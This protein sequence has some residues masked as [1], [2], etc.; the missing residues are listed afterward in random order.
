MCADEEEEGTMTEAERWL[1]EINSPDEEVRLRAVRDLA[2][3]R[4]EE[5]LGR[6]AEAMGDKSWRIRKEAAEAVTRFDYPK[7]IPHLLPGLRDESNAG[8]RNS[9]VEVLIRFGA[10]VVPEVAGLLN[11]DDPDIRKFT[12][13]I[14]GGIDS[15]E[16]VPLLIRALEDESENVV[17]AAAEYLGLKH[18]H[19]AVS[20][21]LTLLEKESFWLRFCALRALGQLAS[22]GQE[23]EVLPFLEDPSLRMETI[24][25]LARIGGERAFARMLELHGVSSRRERSRILGALASILSRATPGEGKGIGELAGMIPGAGLGEEF[26]MYLCEVV[27][28]EDGEE[29]RVAIRVSSLFPSEKVMAALVRNMQEAR[30]EDQEEICRAMAEFPDEYM[31]SLFPYLGT[32]STLVRRQLVSVFG[33]RRYQPALSRLLPLIKDEDGHVRASVATALGHIGDKSAIMPLFDLLDDP[34]PDVRSA[35]VQALTEMASGNGETGEMI[36]RFISSAIDTSEER[37]TENFLLVLGS[38]ADEALIPLFARF[39]KDPRS[40]IRRAA[41]SGLGSLDTESGLEMILKALT[42]EDP[43]I[44]FEAVRHLGRSGNE[45]YLKPILAMVDDENDLVGAEALSSLGFFREGPV[46]QVLEREARRSPGL[47][48][49]AAVKALRSLGGEKEVKALTGLL[50]E[51]GPEARKEIINFLGDTGE[52]HHVSVI[53]P[54]LDDKDWGIR[55]AAVNALGRLADEEALSLLKE[56]YYNLERDP[57]VRRAIEA[58]IQPGE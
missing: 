42:D 24:G 25:I 32:D 40:K 4:D 38:L 46:L 44:R 48:Q 12:V 3:L 13:D 26:E 11:D 8:R 2:S 34:Y 33:R 10:R 47:K 15:P 43:D 23:E 6:L 37:V 52:K 19:R 7:V 16:V 54:C 57:L 29:K 18:D 21:L 9:V 17:A 22:P 45:K 36:G 1:E 53:L 28:G 35:A 31:A 55:L 41:L 58:V 50:P 14:L 49:L 27:Q 20:P 5:H 51:A 39:L 30:E 56:K